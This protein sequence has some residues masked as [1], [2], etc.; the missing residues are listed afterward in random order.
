MALL[1]ESIRHLL[2]R[3]GF[4]ASPQELS[5]YNDIGRSA[6]VEALVDY[7]QFDDD[8]DAFIGQAGYVSVT[9]RGTFSP[10]TVIN[11]ARQRWLFRMVHTARPLQEKMTLFWHNHFATAY[12]KV[13][14]AYGS[15]D[16]TRMMAATPG[17]DPAK[18]R[19]QVE[20]IRA[21]CMGSFR[22]LVVAMAK[23]PAM[24][25]WLDGRFN[26]RQ[27]PQENFGRELMELFSMGVRFYTESDV[28]AA[29][30]VF[31][32]W[33]LRRTTT[34]RD[35]LYP[36]YEFVYNAANH[37]TAAKTFTFP[38]Y[39]DGG[40]TIPSRSAADGMQDG[41]DLITAVAGNP[42]TARRLV[43]RLWNYFVSEINPPAEEFVEDLAGTYLSSGYNIRAVMRRLLRSADFK[44]E[45]N[46]FTKYSWPAEFVARSLKEVGWNGFTVND[47]V[48]QMVNMGQ[49]LYEPPDVAGWEQGPGWIST[50]GMLARMNLAAQLS[51]TQATNLVNLVK[52]V[53][54]T[55]DAVL[56]YFI[57]RLA[58][59][60]YDDGAYNELRA[61]LTAGGAWTGSDT[62]L[63]T[64]VPGLVHLIVGSG[65]Y[66]F[67]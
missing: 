10:N 35:D 18:L 62:Q 38:I 24:L 4:G 61:Y 41:I 16:A 9:T 49:V 26:T 66:V 34:S 5:Y 39:P 40:R 63:R 22:D 44:S 33:N 59:A 50:G 29:A 19:G 6:T 53:A 36:V 30:R 47:A 7:E 54:K 25:V 2:R 15:S 13:A 1:D 32:G 45:A 28:Y 57:D 17:E 65:E 27:K 31:T 52:P 64:K 46:Y 14:G 8:V 48:S 67:I 42:A 43:T 55:P 58:P 12:S 23:D 21:M 51:R 11:D 3:A 60:P 56:S 20:T 37:E